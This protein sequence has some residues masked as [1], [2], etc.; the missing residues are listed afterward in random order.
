MSQQNGFRH[1]LEHVGVSITVQTHVPHRLALCV[2]STP[3]RSHQTQYL[4]TSHCSSSLF[5]AISSAQ[6]ASTNLS[7]HDHASHDG[8]H[9]FTKRV[10]QSHGQR[11]GFEVHSLPSLQNLHSSHVSSS[12]FHAMLSDQSK[13]ITPS[14]HLSYLH[15]ALHHGSPSQYSSSAFHRMLSGPSAS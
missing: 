9:P 15:C 12:S 11:L 2:H 6:L 1:W 7:Q 14:P 5:H 4:H 10:L 3:S 8:E 13:S